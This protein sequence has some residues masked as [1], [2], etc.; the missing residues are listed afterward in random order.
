VRIR[1]GHALN[2]CLCRENISGLPHIPPIESGVPCLRAIVGIGSFQEFEMDARSLRRSLQLCHVNPGELR[3]L[4]TTGGADLPRSR[5]RSSMYIRVLHADSP[6]VSIMT[7][8]R[9]NP[10]FCA[11]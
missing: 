6:I 5:M 8:T 2:I 7:G 3:F 4:P 11:P 10:A 9:I 1:R